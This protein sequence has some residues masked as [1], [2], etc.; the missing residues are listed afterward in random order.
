MK[1]GDIVFM[2]CRGTP[3]CEGRRAKVVMFMPINIFSGRTTRYLCL[4]CNRHFHI[5]Y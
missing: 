5:T 2:P 1:E 4:T 3:G